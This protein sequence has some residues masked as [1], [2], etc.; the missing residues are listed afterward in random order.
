V[1][2]AVPDIGTADV[3]ET[4]VHLDNPACHAEFR[5]GHAGSQSR[6]HRMVLDIAG[7]R[8]AGT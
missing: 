2:G 3:P 5:R 8:R 7:A 6:R 1:D 4:A